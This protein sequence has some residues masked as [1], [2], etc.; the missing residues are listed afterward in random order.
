MLIE[1]N[2]MHKYGEE[3]TITF[4]QSSEYH[5]NLPE[6]WKGCTEQEKTQGYTKKYIEIINIQLYETP[7]QAS[8]PRCATLI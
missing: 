1:S 3:R 5:F 6:K 2:F 8:D 4:G 7:N